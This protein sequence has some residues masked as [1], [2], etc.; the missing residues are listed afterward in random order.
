[1]VQ[2]TV[3][4]F[5]F[6]FIFQQRQMMGL[7]SQRRFAAGSVAA[8]LVL[9]LLAEATSLGTSTNAPSAKSSTIPV[10]SSSPASSSTAT[11][12]SENSSGSDDI[13]TLG[14]TK[15]PASPIAVTS[16]PENVMAG[17]V[18][19]TSDTAKVAETETVGGG[20][21]S[22]AER[23]TADKVAPVADASSVNVDDYVHSDATKVDAETSVA[24]SEVI[25]VTEGDTITSTSVSDTAA[26]ATTAITA[27]AVSDTA[28]TAT[29][30]IPTIEGANRSARTEG[31]GRSFL[32]SED[33]LQ[34]TGEFL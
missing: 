24:A 12:S 23:E 10:K 21:Q 6:H 34:V 18:P 4:I 22:H 16:I 9:M 5:V 8:L 32:V 26:T 17:S 19:V 7:R 20:L 29:T 30:A 27:T 15:R 11:S 33:L 14:A 28:A 3:V 13:T 31:R 2:C 25:G 1:M